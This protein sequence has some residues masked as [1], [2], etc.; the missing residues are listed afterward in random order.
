MKQKQLFENTGGNQFKIQSEYSNTIGNKDNITPSDEN[1][2]TVNMSNEDK[3]TSLLL[4]RQ[5][6]ILYFKLA[7]LFNLNVFEFN[8]NQLKSAA[9]TGK[10]N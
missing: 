1:K 2:Q 9:R 3:Q 6:D 4:L 8:P 10:F 7:N 5:V